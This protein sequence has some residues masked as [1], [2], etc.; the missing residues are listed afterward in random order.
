MDASA[1]K[2]I[3]QQ[4]KDQPP[5]VIIAWALSLQ[6]KTIMTTSFGFYS[7]VSLHALVNVDGG[8][9]TPVIWVDSGY[10]LRDTYKVAEEITQSLNLNL[11]V[12]NPVMSAERRAA[13]MGG[14]PSQDEPAFELFVEQVKIEPFKRALATFN[15]SVWLS[16][17]RQEETEHR[18]QLDI[19][20]LDEQGIL[21]VSPLFYWNEQNLADYLQQH[22]LPNCKHYFDP[23]KKR[24]NMECGL[25]TFQAR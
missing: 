9:N 23:T 20:V 18:K 15:P 6:K 10:N 5:S 1:I 16:G 11:Q 14:V 17:I 7:A 8:Q 22:Q 3:N 19:V 2:K 13:V 24:D 12:F 4:L 21:K 25:H